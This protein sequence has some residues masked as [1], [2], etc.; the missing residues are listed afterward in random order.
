MDPAIVAAASGL[1]GSLIGA[2]S[3]FATTWLTQGSQ[4]RAQSRA[5]EVAKREVLYAE[6]ISEASKR[7]ADA[8]GRQAEGPEVIVALY[9]TVGRMRLMSSREVV[10]AAEKLVHLVIETYASPNLAFEE[11][12]EKL[13]RGEEAD[14]LEEFGEACR[15]EL[16]A[17]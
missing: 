9:A 11:I 6:F 13:V 2:A 5:Q 7:L 12:R 14:P 3:S 1:L 15:A 4:R 8:L 10:R 17:L 16:L